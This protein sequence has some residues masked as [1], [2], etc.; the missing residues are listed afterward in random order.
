M[1]EKTEL[2]PGPK[3][4]AD[5]DATPKEEEQALSHHLRIIPDHSDD[6]DDAPKKGKSNASKEDEPAI[7][8]DKPKNAKPELEA[9]PDPEPKPN[10]PSKAEP[11]GGTQEV[12]ELNDSDADKPTPAPASDIP[13]EDAVPDKPA[14]SAAEA[15]PAEAQDPLKSKL[16]RPSF[17]SLFFRDKP[18]FAIDVG[19]T[20]IKVLQLDH[21]AGKFSVLGYGVSDFDQSVISD[22]VITDVEALA[23]IVRDLLAKK[24][25]G[26]LTTKRVSLTIPS[27]R[28]FI[29]SMSVPAVA[30]KDL[31]S[32]VQ[33]EVEQYIPMLLKELYLDYEIIARTKD[34]ISL[35]VVAVPRRIL[36]SYLALGHALGLEVVA[37]EPTIT[38]NARLFAELEQSN[39][40]TILIDFGSTSSDVMVFDQTLVTASMVSGGGDTFTEQIARQLGV[41]HREAH[42]IK[43]KYGL[44]KSLTQQDAVNALQPALEQLQQEIKRILRYYSERVNNQR[45]IQQIVIMGGG[46]NM[47]GLSEYLT[48][49]LRLPT[50]QFASWQK[51]DFNDRGTHPANDKYI[52]ATV[53]GS[54]L[55][56]PVELYK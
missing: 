34:E 1:E 52:Y 2:T 39:M 17:S 45:Q 49:T 29:R 22:G 15:K 53:A 37:I 47:P 38:A 21:R 16:P 30:S 33:L 41:E 48:D 18:L 14:A 3:K 43:T 55:L 5:K 12:K 19:W 11:A 13:A 44:T 26:R 24:I 50:R 28:C 35:L 7:P 8:S 54:A 51:I 42:F 32:A 25:H 4:M 40:P 23:A 56:K 6:D 20:S 36:D 10:T 31:M 46:A 9:D 27:K